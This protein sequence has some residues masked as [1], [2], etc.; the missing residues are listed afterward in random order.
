[1]TA[2]NNSL[3]YGRMNNMVGKDHVGAMPIVRGVIMKMVYKTNKY[4]KN[5]AVLIGAFKCGDERYKSFFVPESM[6]HKFADA[7]GTG[8]VIEI[9]LF[10]AKSEMSPSGYALRD[11]PEIDESFDWNLLN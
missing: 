10:R 4:K 11:S 7:V 1:M 9:R 3:S 5:Q 2:I 8:E 6:G